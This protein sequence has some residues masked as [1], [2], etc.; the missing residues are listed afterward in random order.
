M[1]RSA[2][3]HARRR[4]AKTHVLVHARMADIP[5]ILKMPA[6]YTR[7]AGF[8]KLEE[9]WHVF[10]ANAGGGGLF[11]AALVRLQNLIDVDVKPFIIGTRAG[12]HRRIP[13]FDT[14]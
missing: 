14:T 10:I 7:E 13:S 1:G 9:N 3:S 11:R 6:T 5:Q 12:N 4:K 8:L 2:G